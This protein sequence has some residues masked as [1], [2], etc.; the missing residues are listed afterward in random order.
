MSTKIYNGFEFKPKK[1]AKRWEEIISAC[2]EFRE[3]AEE[4]TNAFLAE[5]TIHRAIV[6]HD[7]ISYG[8]ASPEQKTPF[9]DALDFVTKQVREAASSL[10]HHPFDI[11]T[12]LVFYPVGNRIF[13]QY[14]GSYSLVEKYWLSRPY[15]VDFHYQNQ[16]DR[17]EEVP[18]REW[19][20]RRKV[21]ETI[22]PDYDTTPLKAGLISDIIPYNYNTFNSIIHTLDVERQRIMD[23]VNFNLRI[24]ALAA[25]IYVDKTGASMYDACQPQVLSSLILEIDKKKLK[26][27]LVLKDL[28]RRQ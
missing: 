23:K 24:K 26:K 16:T 5:K 1:I 17:P 22:F 9:Y 3:K 18:S 28:L 20:V 14:F 15:V 6:L 13:G 21:W 8:V 25:E 10:G 11:A 7:K 27:R 4:E 2:A 19:S 12:S